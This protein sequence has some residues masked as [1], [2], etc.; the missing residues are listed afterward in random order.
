MLPAATCC[1]G[2]LLTIDRVSEYKFVWLFSFE[3]FQILLLC[4]NRE[5]AVF[6]DED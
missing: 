4:V 3:T 5:N 1:D 6:A 2:I